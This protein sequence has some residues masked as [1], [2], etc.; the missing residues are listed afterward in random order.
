VEAYWRMIAKPLE[1]HK[2]VVQT[3]NRYK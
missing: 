1:V 3:I 2:V